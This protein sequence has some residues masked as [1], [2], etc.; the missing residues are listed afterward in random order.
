YIWHKTDCHCQAF[1]Q[2][3]VN[4]VSLREARQLLKRPNMVVTSTMP[5]PMVCPAIAGPFRP[6]GI[7]RRYSK[8]LSYY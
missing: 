8:I 1:C 2:R 4:P 7:Q 6:I 5:A 3:S